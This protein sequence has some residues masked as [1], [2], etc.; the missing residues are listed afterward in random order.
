VCIIRNMATQTDTSLLAGRLRIALGRL[1]RRLRA[2]RRRF[3]LSQAAVLGR[4]DRSGASSIGALAS[5]EGVRPQSMTPIVAEL[6]A[7][8]LIARSVDPSDGRRALVELTPL[9]L[10]AIRADR[11]S[12]EDWLARRI[13]ESC[14]PQ[15]QQ[16]LEDAIALLERLAQG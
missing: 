13:D 8:G 5:A 2:E 7:E 1:I 10:E 14:S 16:L 12:R 9:G 15:E 3:S 6:E 11:R 4:L